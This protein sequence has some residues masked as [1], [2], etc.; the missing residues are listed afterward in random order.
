M[1]NL[2]KQSGCTPIA[3]GRF[4]LHLHEDWKVWGPNG[5]YLS[6]CV[7]R[8]VGAF[9]DHPLP[10]SYY[11]QYLR[12][13]AFGAAE[14][15]VTCVKRGRTASA[16]QAT[17]VQ[18]DKPMLQA[19]VWA[20][21]GGEGLEHSYLT[22]QAFFVPLEEA[23]DTPPI[24]PMPFWQNLEIR[25]V[26]TGEGHYSQWYRF[27]HDFDVSDAFLDAARSAILIDTMQWPAAWHAQGEPS[28]Y[29]APSLDL[30][31]RFHRQSP[32]SKW[33]FSDAIADVGGAGLLAGS[34]AVWDEAGTLLTSGGSQSLCLPYSG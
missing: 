13:P 26:K 23:G 14:V 20:G 33:L 29:V 4:A 31:L 1:G 8:A 11:G 17:L 10:I 3:E 19:L 6:A 21:N 18:E 15:Q 24:G 12:A 27:K 9:S 34:A 16:Y 7:L 5:G 2:S 30:H 25:E 28:S 32:Q 22:Q